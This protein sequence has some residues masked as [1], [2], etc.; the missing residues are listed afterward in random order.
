M[1]KNFGAKAILYPMPVLI[2][3]TYD[4]NGKPNAMNAAWGGISEETEIS[5][6]ISDTHKTAEN[7]IKAGAF[8]VSIADREN[9]VAADYVGIVSGNK[10]PDKIAK[11]GWTA[12]KS[13]FVDAPLFRDLP[14]ALEC[15]LI[16]YDKATCRLVGE[17]VNVCA[18]E[19]I[20]GADGKI[21]LDKFSP[22]T[23]DPVHHTY[24]VL[25]EVVGKAFYDGKKIK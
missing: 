20:L 25:G 8:T 16:S 22:V 11:C 21:D 2:I 3:G 5:V 13:E 6:C 23:Y 19:S 9:I 12:E 17:I 1:R 7:V 4:E 15:K 10:E 24:R 14:L 18:D